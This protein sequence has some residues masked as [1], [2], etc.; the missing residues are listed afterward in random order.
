M[1]RIKTFVNGGSLLP[2]DLDSM[3]DDYEVAYGTYKVLHTT[4]IRLDAPAAGTY[5]FLDGYAGAGLAPSG[6]QGAEAALYKDPARY[7][8]IASTSGVNPRT[9][10]YNL[11]VAA[12]TNNTATTVTFTTGLYTVTGTTGAGA[13]Q[14][15]I[16]LNASP[17][18][19]S[20]VA[21]ATPAAS[22]TI[23]GTWSGDF[24]APA[25][26]WLA[27]A[28]VVSAAAA[29]SSSIALRATLTMRQV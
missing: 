25:A 2:G 11:G 27:L 14:A 26:G 5:V 9:V 22:S 6:A 10:Y 15:G 17:V 16:T 20:T 29:A 19:G 24:A 18:T 23:A 12:I 21:I 3:E 4:T 28:V 7:W 13:A 8:T 1:A